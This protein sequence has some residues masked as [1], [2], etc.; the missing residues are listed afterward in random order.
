MS[1]DA[2]RIP[3]SRTETASI[4]AQITAASTTPRDLFSQDV[5]DAV[6]KVTDGVPR[7]INQLCD[8]A[9]LRAYAAGNDSVRRETVEAW[10]E[11]QQLPATCHAEP[12]EDSETIIE[13]GKLDDGQALSEPCA[14]SEPGGVEVPRP[15]GNPPGAFACC[16]LDAGD[17]I[18]R[19]GQRLDALSDTLDGLH[20][21]PGDQFEP[22][23]RIIPEVN[24]VYHDPVDLLNEDFQEEE[25]I[26]DRY[27]GRPNR[28]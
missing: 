17:A 8:H 22:A 12:Q 4:R 19:S 25:V 24:L 27:V 11:L 6:H 3:L 14:M 10:A 1:P 7:L 5:R 21:D 2:I 16:K 9:L 15:D 23:G 26:A 13:F 28:R 18:T 20:D